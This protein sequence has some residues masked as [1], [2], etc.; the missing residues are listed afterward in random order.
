MT[1]ILSEENLFKWTP[2]RKYFR[3]RVS[4]T[5]AYFTRISEP[6]YGLRVEGSG[7]LTFQTMSSKDQKNLVA[8]LSFGLEFLELVRSVRLELLY[9]GSAERH[10]GLI[11]WDPFTSVNEVVLYSECLIGSPETK[12]I[13]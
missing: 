11:H 1:Y 6:R 7:D 4:P 8:F 3:R 9:L 5:W 13:C 2:A 12:H 10:K